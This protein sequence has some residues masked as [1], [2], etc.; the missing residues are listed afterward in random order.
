MSNK[1]VQLE[2]KSGDNLYPIAGGALTGSISK[3]MLEEG[4]FEGPELSQPSSVAYVATDN[5]QDGAVTSDKIDWTTST[6]VYAQHTWQRTN[7]ASSQGAPAINGTYTTDTTLATIT[8]TP[9]KSGLMNIEFNVPCNT[10]SGGTPF[11]VARVDG[12]W[13]F[14]GAVPPVGDQQGQSPIVAKKIVQ[15]TPNVQHTFKLDFS[16]GNAI[17]SRIPSLLPAYFSVTEIG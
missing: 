5:I 3:T 4:I 13:T 17:S 7:V 2:N 9:V 6:P 10:N 8:L 16:N 14:S 15:V 12:T 11:I 1:I